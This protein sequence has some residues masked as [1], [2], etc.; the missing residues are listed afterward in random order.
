MPDYSLGRVR[1]SYHVSG[2]DGNPWNGADYGHQLGQY[3]VSDPG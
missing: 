2:L 1:C 3:R